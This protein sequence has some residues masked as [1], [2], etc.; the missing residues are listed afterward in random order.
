VCVCA[1]VRAIVGEDGIDRAA[2]DRSLH[3]VENE[4]TCSSL[5]VYLRAVSRLD[6]DG[7]MAPACGRQLAIF[8]SL[9]LGSPLL[10]LQQSRRQ[11]H[12]HVRRRNI[13]DARVQQGELFWAARLLTRTWW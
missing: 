7:W 11:V 5:Q 3:S 12:D 6:M 8:P 4:R 2:F 10:F 1:S 13:A 9:D